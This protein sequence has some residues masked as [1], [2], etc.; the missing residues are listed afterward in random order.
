MNFWQ[1]VC[2]VVGV[3]GTVLIFLAFPVKVQVIGSTYTHFP[4]TLLRAVAV[5]SCTAAFTTL[6]GIIPRNNNI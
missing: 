5:A 1:K 3:I 4:A 2:I 6:L